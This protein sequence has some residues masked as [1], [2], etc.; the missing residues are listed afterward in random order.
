MHTEKL[1]AVGK[2]TLVCPSL[3]DAGPVPDGGLF[4][5]L[6]RRPI[7]R[8]IGEPEKLTGDGAMSRYKY[9]VAFLLE[10]PPKAGDLVSFD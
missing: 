8:V 2:D 1:E 6:Q 9:K 10:P 5:D 4:Y 7:A 3:R